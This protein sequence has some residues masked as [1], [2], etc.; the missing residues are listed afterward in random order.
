MEQFA[1]EFLWATHIY[2][3][4][5]GFD[6]V[7]HLIAEGADFVIGAGLRRIGASRESGHFLGDIA[8]FVNPFFAAAI[9]HSCIFMPKQ[10]KDPQS[11]TSPPVIFITVKNDG[12]VITDAI[13]L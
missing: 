13:S 8:S 3:R 2:Q 9:H 6:M 7:Q 4:L 5:T 11:I 12:G 10:L 1:P